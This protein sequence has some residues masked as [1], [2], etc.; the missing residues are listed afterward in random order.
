M[1]NFL[2][3]IFD[4]LIKGGWLMIPLLICSYF[5][6]AII[7][8]RIM[9]YTSFR[10]VHTS[11]IV[12]KLISLVE[13]NK[14]KQA[15]QVCEENPYYLTNIVKAGLLHYTEG[16]PV[17]Q[18][19][20]DNASLYEIPRLER[21]LDFLS[22]LAHIS[23]LLGLLGTV[24][25]LVKSFNAIEAKAALAGVVSPSDVAG[26]IGEALITTVAGL[27]VGIISYIAYNYFVHK[28]NMYILEAE[29]VSTELLEKKEKQ[30]FE[31]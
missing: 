20:M 12:R 5:S 4:V 18:E 19:A 23:P 10:K 11:G 28:V 26:G 13:E 24:V 14:I 22:T 27:C 29:K 30:L 15:V 17:M 6:V 16:K 21:N 31:L 7:I 3:N 9:F 25:G 1:V 2:M 8:E